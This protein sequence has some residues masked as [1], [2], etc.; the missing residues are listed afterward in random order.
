MT[1]FSILEI[2]WHFASKWIVQCYLNWKFISIFNS[3]TQCEAWIFCIYYSCLK[4]ETEDMEN[5]ISKELI[6]RN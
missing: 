6:T 2:A 1:V 4:A 3:A 5:N